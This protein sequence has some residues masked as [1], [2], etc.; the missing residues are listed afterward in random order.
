LEWA[1][2]FHIAEFFHEKIATRANFEFDF[3]LLEEKMFRRNTENG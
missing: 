2:S 3:F 1:I